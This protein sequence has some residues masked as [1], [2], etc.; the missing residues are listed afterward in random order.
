MRYFN[1]NFNVICCVYKKNILLSKRTSQTQLWSLPT[2]PALFIT[3]KT[4][5]TQV[6]EQFSWCIEY[7]YKECVKIY[8]SHNNKVQ[9]LHRPNWITKFNYF[10]Q[11]CFQHIKCIIILL[12][13]H[14]TTLLSAMHHTFAIRQLLYC[15]YIYVV[16]VYP[17]DTSLQLYI[18]RN[19]AYASRRCS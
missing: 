18:H 13:T 12:T 7:H 11:H 2:A 5:K 16:F 1:N 19:T 8:L 10:M 4:I 3:I 9:T 6:S 14:E 15:L 17:S